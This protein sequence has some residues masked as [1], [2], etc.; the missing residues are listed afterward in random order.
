MVKLI[1]FI[2]SFHKIHTENPNKLHLPE[3]YLFTVANI[4]PKTLKYLLLMIFTLMFNQSSTRYSEEKMYLVMSFKTS[5][6]C[7]EIHYHGFI[8]KKLETFLNSSGRNLISML[9]ITL[10]M[11]KNI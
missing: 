3:P 9:L 5:I 1:S 2:W 4:T 8:G 7:F 11:R 10:N 6:F